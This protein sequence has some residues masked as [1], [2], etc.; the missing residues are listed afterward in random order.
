MGVREDAQKIWQ[1]AIAAVQPDS[2]VRRAL[3][4][5]DFTGNVHLVAIGKAAW[6]MAN[7][8][9]AALGGK[10]A[11]GVVITKYGHAQGPIGGLQIFE[12]AH[13][14]PDENSYRATRAAMELV[15]PLGKD[16][17]KHDDNQMQIRH[18]MPREQ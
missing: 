2:A 8:A 16:G 10:I 6:S 12:A 11:D 13:P 9:F 7:A 18:R 5:A 1:Q 4:T 15:K 14:V 17:V 3:E